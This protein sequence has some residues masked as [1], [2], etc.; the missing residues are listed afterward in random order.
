MPSENEPLRLQ[1]DRQ[2][3]T[4]SHDVTRRHLLG[5]SG[6]AATGA[7]AGCSALSSEET[8]PDTYDHLEQR[9]VY[10]DSAVEITVPDS[11]QL[12]ETPGDADLIVLP[13]TPEIEVAQAVEWL[14]ETRAIA[15]LGDQS[16][17]TW[18]SWEQSDAY[19]AAFDPQGFGEGDP[20]PDLL[21][22][23]NTDPLITT[24]QYGWGSDPTDS[25]VLAALNK[26]LGEI[27]PRTA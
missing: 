27:E 4:D 5:A 8:A 22:A 16:Q 10:V 26:T 24:Q 6:T 2:T 9:P 15:L 21:I 23:W 7:V 25:D 12:V 18:L 14:E 17:R 1:T 20:E 13:D 11:V 19:V 3:S